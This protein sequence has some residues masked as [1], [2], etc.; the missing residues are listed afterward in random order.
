MSEITVTAKRDGK[1][2]FLH[3]IDHK[4]FSISELVQASEELLQAAK[5]LQT[6][7]IA[8]ASLSLFNEV[9]YL[10]MYPEVAIAIGS[11]DVMSAK[12]HYDAY[13]KAEG[14]KPYKDYKGV[15]LPTPAIPVV[16]LSSPAIPLVKPINKAAIVE[17]TKPTLNICTLCDYSYLPKGLSLY[18]SLTELNEPFILHWLCINQQAYDTLKLLNLEY[19]KLY[20]LVDLEASD[21]EL[22][23][24]KSNP[25]SK[26]GNQY[27]QYCWSLAPYFT[28]YLL[29]KVISD[30]QYLIYIDADIF[31]YKSL[32]T[33]LSIV[34]GLS[35]GIHTHR[36]EGEYVDRPEGWFNIGIVIVKKDT[37]GC[38]IASLWKSLLMTQ[39]HDYFE[40]Y[41]TCGD[42]KYMDLIYELYIKDICIFDRNDR[43]LHAA[44]WCCTGIGAKEIHFYHFS[45]FNIN[46][47]MVWSDSYNGEWRPASEDGLKK[48]Y[49]S[50][51][52]SNKKAMLLIDFKIQKP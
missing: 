10:Q 23:K 35:L 50:Y 43:V 47:D 19:V 6:E 48:Y 14:R 25:A 33:I 51:F 8:K 3:F 24:C 17:V 21:K 49:E 27:S 31:I 46:K 4:G 2:H 30:N 42:Q 16:T 12:H 40:K 39:T 38:E 18:M 22:M 20:N 11:G 41:G 29:N 32:N 52:K 37:V 36:F 15:T 9:E 13:G 26:Y 7:G 1:G 45:H 44:P 34:G 5:E 28:D